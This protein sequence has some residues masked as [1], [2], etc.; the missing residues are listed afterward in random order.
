[1]QVTE[2]DMCCGCAGGQE[3]RRVDSQLKASA[4]PYV[5]LSHAV[6]QQSPAQQSSSTATA[7]TEVGSLKVKRCG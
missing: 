2:V 6:R 5:P 3:L 1:M 7:N 4:R